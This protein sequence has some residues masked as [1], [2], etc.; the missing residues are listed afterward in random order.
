M[1]AG[2]PAAG[3]YAGAV[4]AQAVYLGAGLLWDS[5]ITDDFHRTDSSASLGPNWTNRLGV[6]GIN[7]DQGYGYDA[8]WNMA[9]YNTPASSDDME[10]EVTFGSPLGGAI[11]DVL[12]LLGCN[13]A[14]EGIFA[15]AHGVGDLFIYTQTSW[16]NYTEQTAGTN[17]T[18]GTGSV[19]TFRRV[20]DQYTVL[21]D[22]TTMITW[23]DSGGLVPRDTAHRLAGIGIYISGG[24]RCLG[25]FRLSPYTAVTAPATDD[26]NRADASTL[27]P[28]WT[29]QVGA[30]GIAGDGAY[31]VSG[32]PWAQTIYNIPASA[33]DAEVSIQL[34]ATSGGTQVIAVMLGMNSAGEGAILHRYDNGGTT[35]IMS[36]ALWGFASYASQA[37]VSQL[38]GVTGDILTLKRVG[39]VYSVLVNGYAS[40][41]TWTD[42][43]GVI[44]RDSNHRQAGIGIYTDGTGYRAIDSFTVE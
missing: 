38:L 9:S 40:G 26:F 22:G 39:S 44:P 36:Q 12:V 42:S 27:G 18:G 5:T 4:A 1:V 33:D 43:S 6:M 35:S 23:I 8:A 31:P 19:L 24:G 25:S 21:L 13:T 28:N 41:L 11:D 7:S 15:Y 32:T 30:M 3:V 16:G 2:I 10:V 37:S 17:G 14:G 29:D 34:G 20:G